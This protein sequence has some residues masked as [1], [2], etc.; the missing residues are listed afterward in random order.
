MIVAAYPTRGLDP[1]ASRT[2]TDRILTAATHGAAVIWFGAELDELL[3]VA[4]RLL[5][6]AAASPPALLFPP[7]Q[8]IRHRPSHDRNPRTMIAINHPQRIP[9]RPHNR[10]ASAL[11]NRPQWT[12]RAR[13]LLRGSPHPP[14]GG[15]APVYRVWGSR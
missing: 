4:D 6:L 12:S 13:V 7:L 8:P 14:G 10:S 9:Q 15:P 3:T 1:E 2:I 11:A 5:V